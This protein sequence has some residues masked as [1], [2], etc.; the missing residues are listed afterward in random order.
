VRG[1]REPAL[2]DAIAQIEPARIVRVLASR[3]GQ[4][5][6][7]IACARRTAV[8]AVAFFN[9]VISC[10]PEVADVVRQCA[11]TDSF[12][13]HCFA[14][15]RAADEKRGVDEVIELA[16]ATIGRL[17]SCESEAPG[18]CAEMV[19]DAILHFA[20]NRKL[21]EA[22]IALFHRIARSLPVVSFETAGRLLDFF[23]EVL[24]NETALA[25]LLLQALALAVIDQHSVENCFR[26]AVFT[27]SRM[28]KGMKQT[29]AQP[30]QQLEGQK[31]QC[32]A[33][34]NSRIC[35]AT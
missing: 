21:W 15:A 8:E 7:L 5:P 23:T 28:F 20:M 14:L 9:V 16:I 24:A 31:R 18:G 11:L 6:P 12:V 4:R 26:L 25:S 32:W 1:A 2:R 22:A 34:R 33:V 29:L 10:R 35:L 19:L 17:M 27:R 3:K 30:R 13:L